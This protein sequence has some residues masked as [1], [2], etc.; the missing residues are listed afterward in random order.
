MPV[1]VAQVASKG[2]AFLFPYQPLF[3]PIMFSTHFHSE[4]YLSKAPSFLFAWL[5]LS[6][7]CKSNINVKGILWLSEAQ[8]MLC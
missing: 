8:V 2:Q 7:E 4:A 6:F 3:L 5:F 1:F